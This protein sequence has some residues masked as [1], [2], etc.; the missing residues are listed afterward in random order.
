MV[1]KN[2]KPT[3][4][5]LAY[6]KE[7]NR[8]IKGFKRYT[9]KGYVLDVKEF[10]SMPKRT[11]QKRIEKLKEIKP[12]DLLKYAAL[13]DTS[14]GEL[15]SEPKSKKQ[16]YFPK[17]KTPSKYKTDVITPSPTPVP[18]TLPS[19][20]TI[21]DAYS[22]TYIPYLS[23]IDE[24]RSRIKSL[25]SVNESKAHIPIDERSNALLRIFEDSI[26]YY[27]DPPE[28]WENYLNY[29]I[30]HQEELFNSLQ[31]IKYES[32]DQKISDS[33][34]IAGKILNMG[35]LSPMQAESLHYMQEM[36]SGY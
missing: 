16:T 13:V 6:Q 8:L 25:P 9:K 11:T 23:I 21:D 35:F 27:E 5:Q 3:Q 29:L 10:I 30:Q 33:F 19:I 36:M 4:N 31:R 34:A 17:T 24:I 22:E 1:R 20:S 7:L 2:K 15:V 28:E 26:S 12:K 18:S 14:T 32:T